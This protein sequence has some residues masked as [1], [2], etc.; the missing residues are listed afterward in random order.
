MSLHKL[1][2]A[3]AIIA[4]TQS[5]LIINQKGDRS[6]K[7]DRRAA[8]RDNSKSDKLVRIPLKFKV[9]KSKRSQ[10]SRSNSSCSDEQSYTELKTNFKVIPN[11]GNKGKQSGD[12]VDFS[13]KNHQKRMKSQSAVVKRR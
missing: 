12:L 4:A 1:L 5:I 9:N 7:S 11:K 8:R 3:L 6:D 13:Q 2:A 10:H